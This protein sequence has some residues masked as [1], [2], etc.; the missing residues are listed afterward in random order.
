MSLPKSIPQQSVPLGQQAQD[1]NIY[2]DINWYLFLYNI[3]AQVLGT[4]S[5]SVPASDSDL[6]DFVDLNA[7][8]SDVPQTFRQLA[9]NQHLQLLNSELG[10]ADLANLSQRTA[11]VQ[12]LLP[13]AD[14][15]AS[16]RDLANALLLATDTLL[17]DPI[18]V[19]PWNAP[20][21]INSWVNFGAGFNPAGYFKDPFGV[22][23][24]RGT[25]KSGTVGNDIFI[26]PAGYR[27]AN[28]EILACVSNGVLGIIE[29]SSGGNVNATAGNNTYFSLDGLTF[30]AT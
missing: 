16:L 29:V 4:G 5:G 13:E 28:T 26:L 17:P 12:A 11:N 24:L 3:S 14:A 22:V 9:N 19:E 15:A 20:T 1:G 21:L 27:P 7:E 30:R 23:H 10:G 2:V 25:V 18:R 6:L 8:S